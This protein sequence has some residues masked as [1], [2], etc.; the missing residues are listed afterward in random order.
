MR[1]KQVLIEFDECNYRVLKMLDILNFT[2]PKNAYGTYSL[3]HLSWSKI[4]C[5]K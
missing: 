1:L 4:T 3:L 2:H 5:N